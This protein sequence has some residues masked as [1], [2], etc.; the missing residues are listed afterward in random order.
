MFTAA[1]QA[2]IEIQK[3]DLDI[4]KIQTAMAE[5]ESRKKVATVREK[6]VQVD[7]LLEKLV[8]EQND[9]DMR[10]TASQDEV[11]A[12]TTKVAADTERFA[13][14]VSSREAGHLQRDIDATRRRIDALEYQELGL[15]EQRDALA[16]K[17][18]LLTAKRA[19]FQ[20]VQ[21]DLL[22]RFRALSQHAQARIAELS[23]RKAKHAESVDSDVMARYDHL[24]PM[25]G[26][27]GIGVLQANGRC[28]ACNMTLAVGQLEALHAGADFSTCPQ[29]RRILV[30]GTLDGTEGEA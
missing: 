26:G 1:Q 3:L 18:G 13:A 21:D 2:L 22:E 6:L 12:L 27:V 9:A 15:M 30:V 29:C 24:A 19:E 16:E 11:E 7:Q 17:I 14:G 8:A 20:A 10:L 28:S 4:A 5:H 25:K 23:K